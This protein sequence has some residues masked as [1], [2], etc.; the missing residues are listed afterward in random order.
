MRKLLYPGLLAAAML[1]M[2]LVVARSSAEENAQSS[3]KVGQPAP[4][5]ALQDHN[6][7]AVNL[8]DYAGKIVVLEWFNNECPFVQKFYTK[9]GKMNELAQTYTEKGVVWL[10]INSGKTTTNEA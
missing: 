10:A 3:A 9:S 8:S 2:A 6:G 1:A 7:N 4:Q 5:F